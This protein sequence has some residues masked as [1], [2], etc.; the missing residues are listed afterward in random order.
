MGETVTT[1]I[2]EEL[3]NG[4]GLCVTVCP[5]DTITMKGKK[6]AVT[7]NES[8]NCGHCMAVCPTGAVQVASLNPALSTFKTF[9]A[10]CEWLPFG[11]GN[12]QELVRLMQSR[13]SCRNFQAKAVPKDII[14]DLV[15]I[16]ISAPSGTNSQQW[17]FTIL[18]DRL[19]VLQLAQWVGGFFRKMNR[20]AENAY[21]RKTLQLLGKPELENY[22]QNHYESIREGLELWEKEGKDLLF[23]G[24]TAAIVVGSK[25]EATCPAEDALLATQN[26]LLSAHVLGIGTCLIGFA[27]EAMKRDKRIQRGIGMP[28][29]ENAYAVIALGYP[30]EKY[31]RLAG[32]KQALIRYFPNSR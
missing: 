5:S 1:T 17:T 2:D 26:I 3:C 31:Q 18:P 29:D 23:H 16:G 12:I 30:N 27:V 20:T 6:A 9:E 32:R 28:D 24:A 25:K 21:L 14:E 7:G 19:A 13:R 11:D 15:K 8:L 22:F 4:C 10:K